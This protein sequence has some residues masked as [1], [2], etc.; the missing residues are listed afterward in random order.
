MKRIIFLII[1]AFFLNNLNAEEIV[2]SNKFDIRRNAVYYELFGNGFWHSVNYDRLF[3]FNQKS[4]LVVRG[5]LSYYEKVFTLGEINFLTGNQKHHF[6][7]GVGYTAFPE[8]HVVFFR[9]GYR[10]HGKK[11]FVLRASPLYCPTEMFFWFGIS[12]GYSF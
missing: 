10:Y 1:L 2:S 6:E 12:L 11:G 3:P 4:G 9:T 5:G 8:G 7:T